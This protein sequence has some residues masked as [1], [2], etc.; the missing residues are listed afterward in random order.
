MF[1]SPLEKLGEVEKMLSEGPCK[2]ELVLLSPQGGGAAAEAIVATQVYA[3]ERGMSVRVGGSSSEKLIR[4]STPS[5][6]ITL[7][8]EQ[9]GMDLLSNLLPSF[10]EQFPDFQLLVDHREGTGIKV[11]TLCYPNASFFSI[12]SRA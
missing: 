9:L 10:G 1:L 5:L 3:L 7:P 12:L 6:T 11:H 4:P 8:N 2:L